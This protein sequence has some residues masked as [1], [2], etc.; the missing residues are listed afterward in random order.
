MIYQDL[1]NLLVAHASNELTRY[2]LTGVHFDGEKFMATDGHRL[3]AVDKSRILLSGGKYIAGKTYESKPFKDNHAV[4]IEN[5]TYPNC[6]QFFFAKS[7]FNYIFRLTIPE[8]FKQI[9]ASKKKTG[10][11]MIGLSADGFF[12]SGQALIYFNAGYLGSYAGTE[13]DIHIVDSLSPILI[14]PSDKEKGWQAVLMPMKGNAAQVKILKNPV[15]E[16]KEN[17][18]TQ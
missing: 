9:K 1:I 5:V 17:S 12:T 11:P 8:W 15:P 7:K 10:V 16:T 2:H 13:V 14:I 4:E 18:L 6:Q 3:I